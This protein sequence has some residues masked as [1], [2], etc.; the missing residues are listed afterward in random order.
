MASVC[1]WV[2]PSLNSAVGTVLFTI[3]IMPPPTSFLYFTSARSG[4]MPVV[5]Q[6]MK[7]PIVPVGARTVTW[8]LR[9]PNFSPWARAS[10][11]Q[12]FEPS[13]S[14]AGTLVL[15]MLFTDARCMRMTSRN[16][17]RLMYQPGQAPPGQLS[18]VSCRLSVTP[19]ELE[20]LSSRA[21]GEG[22]DVC[23]EPEGPSDSG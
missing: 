2:Y 13:K 21:L 15:L 20:K 19:C 7:K 3:L 5:S 11:Q 1:S 16:G 10:S 6:S 12:A 18:V 14:A 4:S 22:S 17:S 23:R 8:E 9:Y